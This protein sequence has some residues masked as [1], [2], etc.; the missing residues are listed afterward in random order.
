MALLDGQNRGNPPPRQPMLNLPPA[1]LA[2]IGANVVVHL[3]VLIL[4]REAL[5]WVL[6]HFAF[7]PI[8]YSIEGLGGWPAWAGPVT[9]QFLHGGWLHLGINM[10]MLAAFGSALE[11]TAGVRSMV[12]LYLATGVAGA[13]VHFALFPGSN[14]PVVGASGSISGLFGAVLWLM[15][16]P[17]RFGR[18]S[19]RFWPAALIWIGFSVV[20]GFTGMPGV[21]DGQIAWAAHIG[22]FV[23]GI[24]IMMVMLAIA[25]ARARR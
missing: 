25:K 5:G 2:L 19:I 12:I 1:V 4:P 3:A 8:R 24:A 11:R 18:R 14:I 9:Y 10:V 21:A 7:I 13:F 6:V 20:I 16:R 22:G 17:D 23:A 15:A